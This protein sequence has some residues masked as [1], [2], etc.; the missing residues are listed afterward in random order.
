MKTMTI[1]LAAASFATLAACGGKG[2]DATGDAVAEQHDAAA[3]QIDAQ[4]DQ[5]DA[6]GNEATAESLEAQADAT[7]EAG[8]A[9]E[10]A[11]DNADI[12]T[13]NPAAAAATVP[14]DTM[15]PAGQ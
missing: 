4:A 14:T 1:L 10:E 3:D 9:K 7:R 6:M 13:N 15:K 11:I 2:D 12:Q 8:E 5:A